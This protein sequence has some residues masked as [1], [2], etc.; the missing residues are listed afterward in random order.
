MSR[1]ACLVLFLDHPLFGRRG[2]CL[3]NSYARRIS[4]SGLGS[5]RGAGCIPGKHRRYARFHLRAAYRYADWS[6]GSAACRHIWPYGRIAAHAADCPQRHGLRPGDIRTTDN[7]GLL[8]DLSAHSRHG[9]LARHYRAGRLDQGLA[10]AAW[11]HGWG[12]SARP[13]PKGLERLE[14]S[15]CLGRHT[16]SRAVIQ[17]T[18][19]G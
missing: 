9:T 17:R 1:S 5:D 14:Q 12:N 16:F 7:Q 10:G 3:W 18:K 8:V 6:G 2:P 19:R 4:A 13:R 15:L 11:C